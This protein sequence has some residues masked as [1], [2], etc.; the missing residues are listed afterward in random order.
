MAARAC[1]FLIVLLLA[2][3]LAPENRA[4]WIVWNVGQGQWATVILD[5]EC[6]HYDMGGERAPWSRI[7]NACRNFQNSVHLSHWDSDHIN[8][9]SRA[10]YFLPNLCRSRLPG[11]NPSEHKRRMVGRVPEC[12]TYRPP[13]FQ[14]WRPES[15][16]RRASNDESAIAL[17]HQ[18]LLPGDSPKN[19]EQR[20][21][22]ELKKIQTAKFLVLGHH[23][24]R[25]STSPLLLNR[26]P[27]LKLA[28]ASAR[29]RRYGHPHRETID[30]LR[31]RRIPLLTTE[32]W[33]T[34]QI[35]L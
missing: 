33:G 22:S 31:S 35:W 10:N 18:A 6:R 5:G 17:D 20:W 14:E 9:T 34:I 4:R 7:M 15:G 21:A 19:M 24:S 26:L 3:T 30:L 28:I 12:G 29:K 25:T 13:E 1:V 27:Q 23:G 16:H 8:F 2:K 32:E 11:G